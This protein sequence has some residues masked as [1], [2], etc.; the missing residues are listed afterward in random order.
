M[1]EG[2]PQSPPDA[3]IGHTLVD[4]YRLTRKIGEGALP[5]TRVLDVTRQT[6]SALAAAHARGIVHRDVKPE[7]IFLIDREGRDF[8]KVLDFGISKTMKPGEVAEESLRLTH[9]G[10]ILGTPL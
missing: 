7:N 8:V 2:P 6:A 10:M 1:S 9:T 4:R 5:E 3:L